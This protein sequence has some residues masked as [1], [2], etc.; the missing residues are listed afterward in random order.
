MEGGE[1]AIQVEREVIVNMH[2]AIDQS[3]ESILVGNSPRL[4]CTSLH[5][6]VYVCVVYTEVSGMRN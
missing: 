1:C 5:P 2:S 3:E 6:M 4:H